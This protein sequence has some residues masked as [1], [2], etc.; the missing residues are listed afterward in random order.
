VF[1]SLCKYVLTM[2]SL[3]RTPGSFQSLPSVVSSPTPISPAHEAQI[4]RKQA[5]EQNKFAQEED[6]TRPPIYRRPTKPLAVESSLR[7][8]LATRGLDKRLAAYQWVTHWETI[9]G[10]GI[11]RRTRP[12]SLKKGVLTVEVTD[13]AWAQE[14]QF[15]KQI[16]MARLAKSVNNDQ[17]VHDVR[18]VVKARG[19]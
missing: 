11:A 5:A 17:L 15:R 19:R 18:F 10:T 4:Q 9:V 12:A 1:P 14:L 3:P 7:A 8:V 16:I 2:T 6:E 13:S